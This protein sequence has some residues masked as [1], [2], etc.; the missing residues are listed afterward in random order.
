ML[1]IIK[2]LGEVLGDPHG[3]WYHTVDE[4]AE[5]VAG[6]T[7]PVRGRVGRDR[8]EPFLAG[9][10]A[11]GGEARTGIGASGGIGAGR[12]V[13][14][15]SPTAV[16][17]VR[18]RDVIVVQYPLPNFAPL[19]WDAAGLVALGGAPS[20]HLMEVARSLTVPAVVGCP[21]DDL[22]DVRAT[23]RDRRERST[24]ARS[25]ATR[26]VWRSWSFDGLAER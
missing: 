22:L 2:R 23:G 15:S 9:V 25:T 24:S 8:W 6:R 3:V 14:V 12:L 1:G 16:D 13:W 4:L 5:I 7:S 10:A 21:V 18:P 19:L 20:A 17:H 11:L 26:A